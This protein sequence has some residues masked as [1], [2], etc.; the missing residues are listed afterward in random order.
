[1]TT[2]FANLQKFMQGFD[3]SKVRSNAQTVNLSEAVLPYYDGSFLVPLKVPESS[4]MTDGTYNINAT[5]SNVA[6]PRVSAVTDLGS[7]IG[8]PHQSAINFGQAVKANPKFVSGITADGRLV[9]Q[10][11]TGGMALDKANIAVELGCSAC[12]YYPRGERYVFESVDGRV[13]LYTVT[14]KQ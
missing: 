7:E 5:P 10:L 12:N 11:E 13:K 14:T 8:I 9:T 2:A 3:D 6:Y 1:M 4:T